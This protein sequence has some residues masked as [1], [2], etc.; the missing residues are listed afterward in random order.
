MGS[1]TC[2]RNNQRYSERVFKHSFNHFNFATW[3]I[4]TLQD[5]V[6]NNRP[7]RRTAIVAWELKKNN[8]DIAALSETRFADEGYLQEP[9]GGY[10]F[11]WKGKAANEPRI[12]GVGFAIRNDIV[13]TLPELPT[14]INE[15]LMTLRLHL[16]KK[17]HATIISAYAP[18]LDS[19]DNTKEAFYSDLEKILSATP[20]E[21]KIILMGDFNAR[22]GRDHELWKGTIGKDGVGNINANGVLLLT[23]CA[24][25]GLTVTNTIFR[26]KNHLKTTW[27]H[28]RSKHWHLLDYVIVRSKDTKDVLLTRAAKGS[29][30][31]WTDHRLIRSSMN[32]H[33]S[34]RHRKLQKSKRRKLN[35]AALKNP[36]VKADFQAQLNMTLRH[37]PQ[38]I[39]LTVHEKW[40]FIKKAILV[41]CTQ[42]IG[43]ECRKSQ[44]WFDEN[45]EEIHSLLDRKRKAFISLQN[46]PRTRR[47]EATYR[48]LKSEVQ[49]R[50]RELKDQWW[51][52]KAQ[53]IQSYAD[54]HD[55]RMF[56]QETRSIYGP[57]KGGQAPILSQDGSHLLKES[58]EIRERWREH[59]QQ[60]LNRDSIVT[61]ETLEAFPQCAIKDALD[62][63]PSIIEVNCAISQMKSNKASG[64][65]GIPAEIFK[66]GGDVLTS[67]LHELILMIWDTEDLPE[68]LRNAVIVTIFKKGSKSI[69]GNYRGI[70]LLSIAGKIL[71]RILLNRLRPT[72]EEML[73]ETQ[74]GFRPSRGTADMVFVARQ[75]QEKCREQQQE[76]YLAFI[77]LT[78]AFDSVNREALWTTLHR[79]GC[80]RKFINILRL[81]HD[82]MTAT[83]LSGQ[84]ESTPFK[85]RTG[86][87]QGCV[88]APT[89]FTI[90]LTVTLALI[91]DQLP[92]GVDIQYRLDGKLFNLN[93]LKA[94][95]K[96]TPKVIH[97]LQFADDCCVAAHTASDIQA[98]LDLFNEAYKKLGLS[99]NIGKTKV[100][101]QPAPRQPSN[102]STIYV[103]GKPLEFVEHFPY[104]GSHLSQNATIDEEIQHRIHSASAAFFKLRQRVFE[105]RDLRKST[106]IMVYKAVVITSLLYC[107]ET[108]TTYRRH[109]QTLE[110]FHQRCLRQILGI[111]WEDR[112]TNT[113]V[114]QEARL[115]SIEAMLLKNQLRWA[116][117][118]VRLPENR[119]P[120]QILFSQLTQGQRPRGGQM[121]RYKDTLK[122]S[123]KHGGL[124]TETWEELAEDRPKWRSNVYS[125][126][127][128]FESTRLVKVAEKRRKR[129]EKEANPIL[130]VSLPQST[131]CPHCPK[132]CGSRIGLLS[133]LRTHQV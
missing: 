88:L 68:D 82:D 51:Q 90:Y 62:D 105:N 92:S 64:P 83:V 17:Q 102:P 78:K 59:F 4:R 91:K 93:R 24:Q 111:Y 100:L 10:T 30:D 72:A 71:A 103:D 97:D 49:R 23:K 42:T 61:E 9:R 119:L 112:R 109:V 126:A 15:R 117:H 5:S 21:D 19:D 46:H 124:N 20:K 130:R 55:M 8:I 104:L 118:C 86:V 133:H 66:E 39:D 122:I 129:K 84:F 95:T 22:I 32:I 18:T 70:T 34:S 115:S 116:G 45:D 85:I 80:P 58:N 40:E 87:K 114:L 60:L 123:L 63:S 113:S 74:C 35:T 12:H 13:K 101:H 132:I 120:R 38:N 27:R 69:C 14:G 3:N 79:I 125:A 77:D 50:T 76:L 107:S 110:S 16:G 43:Y 48:Q 53:E 47:K 98:T 73:P 44:D 54:K 106:K 121:K 33:L 7:E 128:S 25:H 108:W 41:T 81:L 29:E 131:S 2:G 11:F 99:L 31:C 57:R 56:F 36:E 26:Q 96:V 37:A 1:P 52:T 89:L 75:I 6:K 28:P 67:A 65:D 94:K 127:E